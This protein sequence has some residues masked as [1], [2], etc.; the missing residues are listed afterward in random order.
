MKK[1]FIHRIVNVKTGKKYDVYCGRANKTHNLEKSKWANPYV[2]GKDGD[3]ELVITKYNL[4]LNS[5]PE[6]LRNIGELKGKVLGCWCDYPKENC[7][8][9]NLLER[10]ESKWIKNWFSNMLP[11]ES[12]MIYNGLK[13][14]SV[15]NFYQA[16]KM[17]KGSAAREEISKM[18]PFEAKKN[19]R[20]M[21]RFPWRGDWTKDLGL[22]VMEH[23]LNHKFKKGTYW[24]VLL[25][26]SGELGLE[27][28]EWNNWG[29]KFWGKD[30]NSGEGEN[31][32]GK[33]LM[34]IRST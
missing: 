28:V 18:S 33:I 11:F 17:P 19:I 2:I 1:D 23:A 30:L 34:K 29:D 14:N 26:L 13:F 15:E 31:H 4:Y 21:A 12:P 25:D 16:M 9:V 7:H 24:R 5:Q 8:C 22:K 3:R 20:D 10:A 27:L 32:L 6:L